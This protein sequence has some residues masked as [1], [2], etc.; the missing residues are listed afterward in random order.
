MPMSSF[1]SVC[2][3]RC[4]VIIDAATFNSLATS[5]INA[6]FPDPAKPVT[7]IGQGSSS[8]LARQLRFEHVVL[9]RTIDDD[10]MGEP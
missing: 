1:A 9:V 7:K 6:V 3:L 8:A 4:S 2:S 5:K 10:L